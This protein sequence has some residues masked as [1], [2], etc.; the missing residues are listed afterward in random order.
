MEEDEIKECIVKIKTKN[1]HGTGFF[2]AKNKILTCFHVIKDVLEKDIKVILKE[3]EYSVEIVDKK[4]EFEIDLAILKV[5]VDNKKFVKIDHLTLEEHKFKSYGFAK[6][7]YFSENAPKTYDRGLVPL[8]FDYEG[9]EKHFMKFKNGQF[10]EGHSGSPIINLSTKA[11]CG[12][13]NASRNTNS[14]LGG[15]G[16]PIEKLELLDNK[17]VKM[18]N[19]EIAIKETDTL[20]KKGKLVEQL[21]SKI[22]KLESYTLKEQLSNNGKKQEFIYEN[23]ENNI[24]INFYDKEEVKKEYIEGIVTKQLINDYDKVWI[25]ATNGLEKNA[26]ELVS[27]LKTKQ[28]IINFSQNKLLDLL[29]S[30][31]VIVDISSL[32]RSL[33]NDINIENNSFI[34]FSEYGYFYI[35][36]IQDNQ[37]EGVIVYDATNG[38]IIKDTAILNNLSNLD[39]SFKYLDFYLIENFLEDIIMERESLKIDTNKLSLS[40]RYIKKFQ[41]NAINFNHPYK[42]NIRL[43]DVFIYPDLEIISKK[44]KDIKKS[45]EIN[46]V[47]FT[48]IDE[49]G[50]SIIYGSATSG[51][52]SF[53]YMLQLEYVKNKYIPIIVDGKNI[54]NNGF[55]KEK[56]ERKLLKTFN[57]QYDE[58]LNFSDFKKLEKVILIIDDFHYTFKNDDYKVLFINNL[59]SLGYKHMLFIADE[60]LLLK[61]TTEGKLSEALLDFHH[62]KVLPLGHKLRNE[63]IKKW[64]SLGRESEIDKNDLLHIAREKEKIISSTV[65][66]NL[67]PAYPLYIL[68]LLQSMEA[69]S[70]NLNENSS[71]G[72]YYSFLIMQYLSSDNTMEEKDITTVYGF[73]SALAYKFL[74][75]QQYTITEPELLGFYGDYRKE[76]KFTPSFDVMQKVIH[77]NILI[78]DDNNGYKFSH[79]YLYYYFV[80]KYLANNINNPEIVDLIQKMSDRMYRVEFANI[81][82]FL[83]HHS[84]QNF[85]LEILI[86]K[87][88]QIFKEIKEFT[89]SIK[90]LENINKSLKKERLQLEDKTVEEARE[91]ELEKEEQHYHVTKKINSEQENEYPDYDEEIEELDTFSELNLAFKMI[92]ILGQIVKSN[93]NLDGDLKYKLIDEAYKVSLRTQ[94]KL[95]S[96]IET[97]HSLLL[98]EIKNIIESKNYISEHEKNEI[99]GEMVFAMV[100]SISKGIISK[101][102][103]AVSSEELTIIYKEIRESDNDNL[104]IEL[105]D[106]AII[107]DFKSGLKVREIEKMHK[108]LMND[109]NTLPDFI[110]KKL[111]L[112]HLYMYQTEISVKQ[113]ISTKLGLDDASRRKEQ[114]KAS[115]K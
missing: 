4:E 101:I 83:L 94:G 69:N 90:E 73:L 55:K 79:E 16:I 51:K 109:N 30:T 35:T 91:E 47:N 107:L 26:D 54:N 58:K 93:S 104:A 68:T 70:R 114:I 84:P 98:E 37:A 6:S 28:N 71:Y 108:K 22:L 105:I 96:F 88:K 42:E 2:I 80:A 23:N 82:M 75:E 113:S 1:S 31:K 7:E 19:I 15:Y 36:K 39:I 61:S 115:K 49:I 72:H 112:E 64:V 67:V 8:T 111:V 99:A 66:Y 59:I 17:G 24:Y 48:N 102:A 78:K 46:S 81:I 86:D 103:K 45:L 65:G 14:S 57:N 89:F 41:K 9:N 33:F 27:K 85:I 100:S 63:V 44:I 12:V 25:L 60:S 95:V 13:L 10:E 62:F 56:I 76:K 5:E 11:V 43:E 110:L 87:T 77:T 74:K 50:H 53:A 34:I 40:L 32:D 52:T 97:N 20:I 92:E 106:Q 29:I 38:N 18:I 3:Q 21:V